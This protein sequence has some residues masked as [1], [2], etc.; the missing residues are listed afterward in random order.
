M[1]RSTGGPVRFT[2]GKISRLDGGNDHSRIPSA[3]GHRLRRLS[4]WTAWHRFGN[5]I[6]AHAW[7]AVPI[8]MTVCLV[9]WAG[10][11]VIALAAITMRIWTLARG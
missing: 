5:F 10:W 9:T 2:R 8:W 7:D 1:D 11:Q 4:F 6:A 3:L